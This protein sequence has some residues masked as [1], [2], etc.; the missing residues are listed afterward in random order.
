MSCDTTYRNRGRVHLS[1]S[2]RRLFLSSL[3]HPLFALSAILRCFSCL[4][5]SSIP[6]ENLPR[7]I[8]VL[9]PWRS[10]TE[11]N[12][13]AATIDLS[14]DTIEGGENG[15][16]ARGY[17]CSSP[18]FSSFLSSP[19]PSWL[20]GS[21]NDPS[22]MMYESYTFFVHDIRDVTLDSIAWN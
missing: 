6:G 20:G 2:T 11:F 1:N 9:S 3:H 13:C 15:N 21:S 12:H 14:R 5:R 16:Y 8:I 18:S 7:D 10:C 4:H 17:I 19:P 22:T